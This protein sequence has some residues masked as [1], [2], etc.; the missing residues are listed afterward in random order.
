MPASKSSALV[1]VPT[2]ENVCSDV[3]V[4]MVSAEPLSVVPVANCI[5]REVTREEFVVL[6]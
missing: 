1:H 5:C 2:E 3:D 6:T 4:D